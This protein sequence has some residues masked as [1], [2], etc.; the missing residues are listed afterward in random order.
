MLCLVTYYDEPNANGTM[1]PSSDAEAYAKTLIDQPVVAKYA[2]NTH[3]EPTFKGHEIKRDAFGEI[4]RDTEN[5]GTH[6]EVYIANADVD[7]DGT[8]KNLPCLFA[9][10]R[11]WGRNKN[12][13]SAVKRLYSMGK[14][15]TSW[16]INI[17]TYKYNNG[18]KI[19]EDYDFD[20]NCFLGYEYAYPAGG[21]SVKAVS[22]DLDIP[23]LMIAEALSK[24]LQERI[25]EEEDNEVDKTKSGTAEQNDINDSEIA[26]QPNNNGG[27]DNDTETAELTDRDIRRCIENAYREETGN[28]A[29]ISYVFPDSCT[30]LLEDYTSE[31]KELAFKQVSYTIDGDSVIIND[32]TDTELI[33]KSEVDEILNEKNETII[34]LSVSLKEMEK[35]KTELEEIKQSQIEAENAEKAARLRS[36]A[37]SSGYVEASELEAENSEIAAAVSRLDEVFIK[38]LIADRVVAKAS[39]TDKQES[40]ASE[41][42]LKRQ[43]GTETSDW[44]S[45]MDMFLHK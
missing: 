29:Y 22:S 21:E 34:S 28:Y 7:I 30:A 4:R 6:T 32:I 26:E 37:L 35:Y 23:E 43:L 45:I 33:R 3:G 39:S 24:D 41:K 2:K 44:R 12:V 11:I 15:Y 18:I 42:D 17:N 19:L 31:R 9:K 36:Y 40:A 8:I 10:C 14:L 38:N 13:I 25:L 27:T 1:I 20:S 5:I 16:E